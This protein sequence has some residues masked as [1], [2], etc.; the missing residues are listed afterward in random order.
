MASASKRPRAANSF[1]VEVLE[2]LFNRDEDHGGMP[3]DEESK[4]DQD[5]DHGGMS[6]DEESELDQELEN[7]NE[8]SRY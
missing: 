2:I 6:S 4:L 5:E 7:Q 1:Q 8:F 3:S